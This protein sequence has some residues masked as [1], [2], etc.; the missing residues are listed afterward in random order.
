V[1]ARVQA[2]V[3]CD[4]GRDDQ[5]SRAARVRAGKHHRQ[6]AF[7][8]RAV[9]D[10]GLGWAGLEICRESGE[11]GWC[12][13]LTVA[14]LDEMSVEASRVTPLLEDAMEQNKCRPRLMSGHGIPASCGLTSHRI[15]AATRG[16]RQQ[17]CTTVND[18]AA[19]TSPVLHSVI[20]QARFEG[21][22]RSPQPGPL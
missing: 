19:S 6:S 5:V 3:S 22:Q 11:V 16:A 9:V 13:R 18:C 7:T 15:T 20:A 17:K 4:A 12:R 1:V 21:L 2:A 14:R 8:T 10:V